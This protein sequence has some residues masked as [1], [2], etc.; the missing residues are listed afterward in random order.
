M[1][2]LTAS[3]CLVMVTLFTSSLVGA[4]NEKLRIGTEGVYPPFNYVDENGELAGFDIDIGVALC[5]QMK[6]DCEFVQRDWDSLIPGLVA[7]DYDM[8]VASM[9]ITEEREKSVSFTIPYYSN[10]LSFIGKRNSGIVITD[11]G[12]KGKSVGSLRSTISS[13]YLE[14]HYDGIAEIKLY[15]TQDAALEDLAAG[16]LDLVLGDNLPS[17]D[18]LRTDAGANFEFVGEFIDI[19]DRIGIAVRKGDDDLRES[20]NQ[21]LLAILGDGTYQQLNE[22]YFPF[23]IYF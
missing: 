7:E 18:W 20:L 21:A 2:K 12:L 4:D 19:N 22:K 1:K 16:N 17:F 23:S 14:E 3:I 5:E 9:S 8:I 15:D 6:A 13:A 10:M 11:E